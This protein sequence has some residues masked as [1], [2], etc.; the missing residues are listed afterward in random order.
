LLRPTVPVVQCGPAAVT[1]SVDVG[2]GASAADGRAIVWWR[3]E[4]AVPLGAL[5]SAQ[6]GEYE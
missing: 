4:C 1:A 2:G 5:G 6:L 3:F